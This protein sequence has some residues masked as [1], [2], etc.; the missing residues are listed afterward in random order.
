M[1]SLP[2]R[3]AT[4]AKGGFQVCRQAGGLAK[5]LHL[6]ELQAEDAQRVQGVIRN[7]DCAILLLKL[8]PRP[9]ANALFEGL[10][11][12]FAEAGFHVP[13]ALHHALARHD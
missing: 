7:V 11:H 8:L 12:K 1:T 9:A 3:L 2:E 10:V 5:A 6:A 4:P 13:P